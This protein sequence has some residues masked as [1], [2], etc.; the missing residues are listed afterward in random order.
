MNGVIFTCPSP[1][2]LP[3][4]RF[5]AWVKLAYFLVKSGAV[6]C[7]GDGDGKL[8][9]LPT[10]PNCAL[11]FGRKALAPVSVGIG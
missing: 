10:E 6:G 3:A 2:P 4:R 9:E 5:S 7:Q 8:L 11:P 1:A